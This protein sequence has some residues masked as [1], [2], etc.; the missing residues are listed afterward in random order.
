MLA[1]GELSRLYECLVE[2]ARAVAGCSMRA[3]RVGAAKANLVLTGCNGCGPGPP[4]GG[5]LFVFGMGR[6]SLRC[7]AAAVEANHG[8]IVRAPAV[9]RA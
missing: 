3:Q 7:W 4:L 9:G 1:V 6:F 8:E 2:E 5:L